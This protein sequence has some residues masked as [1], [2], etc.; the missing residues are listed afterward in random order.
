TLA[1]TFQG[2]IEED[3]LVGTGTCTGRMLGFTR[4]WPMGFTVSIG[5]M[6]EPEPPPPPER[7]DLH[8]TIH[9]NPPE[10][11]PGDQVSLW[12]TVTGPDGKALSG[13]TTIWDV[14]N[15]GG[16]VDPR[17][18]WDG[19][20][21]PIKLNVV[22]KDNEYKFTKTLP[23]YGT[24]APPEETKEP[25]KPEATTEATEEPDEDA[26]LPPGVIPGLGGAGKVPGPATIIE[27]IV[28]TLVPGIIG[29][30]G[31]L[32]VGLRRPQVPTSPP[33]G[34]RRPPSRPPPP[35][36][37]ERTKVPPP[38]YKPPLKPPPPPGDEA[39][40]LREKLDRMRKRADRIR[41]PELTKWADDTGK[42]ALKP[43]GTVD[44]EK[45]K[46]SY[47]KLGGLFNIP[48]PEAGKGVL[49][50]VKDLAGL[51]LD[52]TKGLAG[53]L[54][55]AMTGG[56]TTEGQVYVK[57]GLNTV[58][59]A[60]AAI[61]GGIKTF[62]G[63]LVG[64]PGQVVDGVGVISR[65]VRD[66]KYFGRGLDDKA[67]NWINTE[68]AADKEA[69]RNAMKEGRYLDA[70]GNLAKGVGNMGLALGGKVWEVAREFLPADEIKSFFG[71]ESSLGERLWAV[72][73]GIAKTLGLLMGFEKTRNLLNKP[74][75]GMDKWGPLSTAGKGIE[76]AGTAAVKKW[77][78][79]R[80]PPKLPPE[81]PRLGGD[82]GKLQDKIN[83][84]V[85]TTDP[86]ERVRKIEQIYQ[87][88]GMKDLKK[89]QE[90]GGLSAKQAEALN[91]TITNTVNDTVDQS[92]RKTVRD[93]HKST[94]VKVKEVIVADSG[95]SAAGGP[96]SAY[97]DADRTK[98]ITLDPDDVTT[99]AGKHGI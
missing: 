89:L 54:A 31:G 87:K 11:K 52:V 9:V 42:A 37:G 12:A 80:G 8:A 5:E 22:Y 20:E 4:T 69:F 40:K 36:P 66:L 63:G 43:D 45:L 59:D 48:D 23:A 62:V 16:N 32:I 65:T 15:Y 79:W 25:E 3:Q 61:A 38:P 55:G 88:G 93:F 39:A 33:P 27:G 74:I 60:G 73:S 17:F 72:P 57:A 76:K 19:K 53:G 92:V 30:L 49:D 10:P 29:I 21:L 90:A 77:T 99:Y 50:H 47:D 71:R 83:D 58:Y 34:P 1:G 81:P 84:A 94:G 56:D 44:Q 96:R 98:L 26:A 91:K 24:T 13:A 70:L 64:I 14:G 82:L 35:P 7:I 2:Q 41:K 75:P 51:G 6:E 67:R 86:T 95:S 18:T 28:G 97:T 78:E 85:R 46:E 68:G